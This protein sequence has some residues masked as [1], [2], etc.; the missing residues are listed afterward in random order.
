MP[1]LRKFAN[2]QIFIDTL[3][4]RC[5]C[6]PDAFGRSKAQPVLLSVNLVTSVARAAASDRVDLSVD[7]SI[8]GKQL[9]SFENETFESV[10]DLINRVVGVTCKTQGVEK[11]SVVVNLEKGMLLAKNLKWEKTAFVED[12]SSN[13]WKL[14]VE[15]IRIPVIIGIRGNV[16]ERTHKQL[17]EIDLAWEF[18]EKEASDF[19]LLDLKSAINLIAK[20]RSCTLF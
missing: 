17:V 14:C 8:L 12:H 16:H 10:V 9:V 11:M 20:V 2:D 18:A 6:G 3:R 13:E 1:S 4:L 19:A 5:V 7:Y 15:G